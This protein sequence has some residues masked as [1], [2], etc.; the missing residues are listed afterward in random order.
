VARLDFYERIEMKKEVRTIYG[1]PGTGKT[2]T[3]VEYAGR[4]ARGHASSVLFVS[5]SK[6]AATEAVSRLT[7]GIQAMTLHSC[8]YRAINAT[9]AMVVNRAKIMEFSKLVGVPISGAEDNTSEE[10]QEG[11]QY[12]SVMSYARHQLI[13][14]ENAYELK[15]SPGTLER[16]KMF[17]S[18]Y[19]Q[20]KTTYGYIDFDD[21]LTQGLR[22]IKSSPIV[23]VDEAQDCSPLQWQFIDKLTRDSLRVYLAGDDDQA[24]FE[25]SGADP[26]GMK[27]FSEHV[28]PKQRVLEQ[29]HRVPI[30]V[31]DLVHERV[32]GHIKN[33]VPK[34][35]KARNDRGAVMWYDDVQR[36]NFRPLADGYDSVMV[37]VRDRYRMLESQK[38]LD[39]Q[40]VPYRIVGGYSPW[41]NRYAHAI[42]G[43]VKMKED[44]QLTE[45]ELGALRYFGIKHADDWRT[46]LSVPPHLRRMYEHVD[47][48]APIKIVLSTIHQAKGK[49]ADAVVV[50]LTLSDRSDIEAMT[51][52]DAEYRVMYV[53]MTRARRELSLCGGNSLI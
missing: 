35:F 41:T 5:F 12:M 27:K 17:N 1:P 30:V 4:E 8:A 53:A 13:H 16:F 18:A 32:L 37:L 48:F 51:N 11:D 6:A 25:W 43:L 22:H 34:E 46:C 45:L 2:Q 44:I 23:M 40:M 49:E 39:E 9:P 10:Q 28:K 20:W 14:H 36:V 47:L 24:I 3:L 42:R 31:H 26:H 50:D 19:I 52:P 7:G 15:G 38:T 33:R 21:M 29:S